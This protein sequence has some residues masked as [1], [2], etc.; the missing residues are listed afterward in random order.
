[1]TIEER[2]GHISAAIAAFE[3]YLELAGHDAPDEE[4]MREHIVRLRAGEQGRDAGVGAKTSSPPPPPHAQPPPAASPPP[5]SP[6]AGWVFVGT[7]AAFAI[8]GAALLIAA[9]ASSDS[10]HDLAPG[11]T[12]WASDEARGRFETAQTEQ[13]LGIVGLGVGAASL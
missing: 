5:S 7:G 12:P 8:A 10:V 9:K 6:V 13:V 2:L 11:S 4:A 1:G 3:R